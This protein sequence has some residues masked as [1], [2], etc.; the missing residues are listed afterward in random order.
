[1]KKPFRKKKKMLQTSTIRSNPLKRKAQTFSPFFS[2]GF[3][4]ISRLVMLFIFSLSMVSCASYIKKESCTDAPGGGV[5]AEEFIASIPS[6]MEVGKSIKGIGKI[7]LWDSGGIQTSRAAW[8]G[9]A[10][11]RLRIEMLGL[12]GHPVAKFIFDGKDYLFI[13]P[14]DQR[15]YRK[16]GADADLELLT[17]IPVPSADIVMLFSGMIPVREHDEAAFQI[18]EPHCKDILVLKKK[19][20]GVVEKLYLNDTHDQVDQIEMYQWGR[21]VYRAALESIQTVDQ[22]EIPFRL[23]FSNSNRQGFSIDVEKCWPD[24]DVTPEM[25]FIE[26]E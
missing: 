26:A 12:P 2:E 1:M 10:D 15:T 20:H 7:T 21:I 19:W 25:F 22:R 3:Y 8:A 24:M 5:D 14:L 4:L 6:Q 13:S 23:V 9:A 17:G 18:G 16:N 11:G